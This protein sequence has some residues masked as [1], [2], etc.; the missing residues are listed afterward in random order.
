MTKEMQCTLDEYDSWG[1]VANLGQIQERLAEL[2]TIQEAQWEE[3]RITSIREDYAERARF[4][5]D[6][7]GADYNPASVFDQIEAEDDQPATTEEDSVAW[8]DSPVVIE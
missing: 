4:E 2:H 5:M 7:D 1:N 6:H 3:L 8:L